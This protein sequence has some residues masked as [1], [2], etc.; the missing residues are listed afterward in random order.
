[1]VPQFRGVSEP[2]LIAASVLNAA[3]T[4][5]GVFVFGYV[6]RWIWGL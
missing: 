5:A 6:A 4:A 2:T 3:G 1:M